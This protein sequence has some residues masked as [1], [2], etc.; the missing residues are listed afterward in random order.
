VRAE[1]RFLDSQPRTRVPVGQQL[2]KSKP[3]GPANP[4]NAAV[5]LR[6]RGRR[7]P[8]DGLGP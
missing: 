8:V 4:K 3:V 6:N 2:T 5:S 1:K 7:S